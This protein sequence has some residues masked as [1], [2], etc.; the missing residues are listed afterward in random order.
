MA[1][2]LVLRDG[3]PPDID[4][5]LTRLSGRVRMRANNEHDGRRGRQVKS[6]TQGFTLPLA[7]LTMS[8]WPRAVGFGLLVWLLP[9]VIAFLV[10]PLRESAR[11]VFESVMAVAVA[12]T[13]VGLGLVYLRR[14]HAVRPRE[15]LAL[16]VLWFALCVLID[17]PLRLLGGPMQISIGVYFGDI[18]LTYVSIP[19]ITWG[20]AAAAAAARGDWIRPHDLG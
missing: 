17:A 13:A 11:P 15:G 1:V 20:L 4:L 6:S 5:E 9:F 10:F 16:G 12:G 8:S 2:C 7:G 3:Q 14:V 19:L 18:G